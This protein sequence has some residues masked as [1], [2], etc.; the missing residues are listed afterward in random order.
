MHTLVVGS[1][2][3]LFLCS[4]TSLMRPTSVGDILWPWHPAECLSTESL[5]HGGPAPVVSRLLMC[6]Q[7]QHHRLGV[8]HL[9]AQASPQDC[10]ESFSMSS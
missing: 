5:S 1:Y 2:H 9:G 8:T 7:N 6:F 3:P 10:M 4:S